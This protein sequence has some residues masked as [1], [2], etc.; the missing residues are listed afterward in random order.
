MR[1]S[2]LAFA[3]LL[4]LLL[5]LGACQSQVAYHHFRHISSPGWDKSDT[6]HF[7]IKPMTEDGCYE[8]MTELRTDKNYPFQK[9]T[10]VVNEKIFPDGKTLHDVLNCRLVSHEGVIEGDGISSFQYQFH[11]RY[12]NLHKGDS[13]HIS[14]AHNMKREIMPG[15]IDVGVLVR[16]EG[17]K[18]LVPNQVAPGVNSK[19]DKQQ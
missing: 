14:I 19:E 18:E 11:V 17:E 8:V 3:C 5:M 15:I 1:N 10:L 16:K 12:L 7:D 2:R 6:L 13:L 4:P 9:L